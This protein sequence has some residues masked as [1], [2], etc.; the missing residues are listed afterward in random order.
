M[1]YTHSH[2]IFH[3][4]TA[5]LVLGLVVSGLAYSFE[6]ADKGALNA[7]QVMGQ[8]LLVVVTLRVIARLARRPDKVDLG[9]AS[10]ERILAGAVH[11]GLYALLIAFIVTGYVSA[12]ALSNN[13]LLLPGDL[14]FARSDTGEVLLEIHYALKW[15]LLALFGLHFAGAM[16]HALVDRDNTLSSM[17]FSKT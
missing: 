6:L 9:H 3:W 5:L 7:H 1:R 17:W 12:S 16:K 11:L 15:V 13:M 14:A 10:W 4:L 8:A 2:I